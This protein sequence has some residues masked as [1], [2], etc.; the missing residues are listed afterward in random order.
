[1]NLPSPDDLYV[2]GLISDPTVYVPSPIS[3]LDASAV[4][5]RPSVVVLGL[6][7]F[8]LAV[9]VMV[10]VGPGALM[11]S[12]AVAVVAPSTLTLAPGAAVAP[13]LLAALKRM[14]VPRTSATAP[15]KPNAAQTKRLPV[16]AF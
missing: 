12:V 14:N 11:V 15:I 2:P 4:V 5:F 3:D 8:T 16:D 1:M 13:S 6:R 10:V 7:S 9:S